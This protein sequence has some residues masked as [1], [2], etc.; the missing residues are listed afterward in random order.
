[1]SNFKSRPMRSPV[2]T[3]PPTTLASCTCFHHRVACWFLCLDTFQALVFMCL[4]ILIWKLSTQLSPPQ[5]G[6]AF[7]SGTV[8]VVPLLWWLVSYLVQFCLFILNQ[9]YYC[10]LWLRFHLGSSLW[11][12]AGAPLVHDWAGETGRGRRRAA[13][14]GPQSCKMMWGSRW[15]GGLYPWASCLEPSWCHH[16]LLWRTS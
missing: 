10:R 1:M 15:G 8:T 2:H 13:G 4:A 9:Y 14:Y 5:R 12:G 16:L 7:P 6:Q 3:S 11:F